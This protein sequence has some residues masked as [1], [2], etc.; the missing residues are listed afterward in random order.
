VACERFNL[1]PAPFA[2]KE[3]WAEHGEKGGGFD[4]PPQNLVG[5]IV[6]VANFAVAPELRFGAEVAADAPFEI[7]V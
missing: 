2:V 7:P 1:P 6:V 3:A 4:K 5:E